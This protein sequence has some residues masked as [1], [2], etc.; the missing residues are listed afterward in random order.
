MLITDQPIEWGVLGLMAL[1]CTPLLFWRTIGKVEQD[2]NA[3][4]DQDKVKKVA[5]IA[6]TIAL[7]DVG[8]AD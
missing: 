2:F 3:L 6:K 4:P 8:P 1:I 5:Q 7:K